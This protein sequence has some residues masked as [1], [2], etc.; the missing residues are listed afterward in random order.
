MPVNHDP[1]RQ[2][3]LGNKGPTAYQCGECEHDACYFKNFRWYCGQHWW[4][5]HYHENSTDQ[6]TAKNPD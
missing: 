6:S 2:R 5:M 4:L 1:V 3:Q